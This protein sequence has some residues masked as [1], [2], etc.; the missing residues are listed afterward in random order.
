[1]FTVRQ[2]GHG[3]WGIGE[4]ERDNFLSFIGLVV[5][6]SALFLEPVDRFSTDATEEAAEA[7]SD[8][9]FEHYRKTIQSSFGMDIK[10]FKGKLV[11]GRADGKPL[12]KY[13]LN[14]LLPGIK[15]ELE[16]T[17]DKF[18]AL[19]IATDHLEEFPD[20]YTRLLDMEEKAE[21]EQKERAKKVNR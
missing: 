15:V 9:K 13:D 17:T 1:L 11:G 8:P 20:Y 18:L 3:F 16:H 4:W 21:R 12:T 14:E 19:E 10:N 2:R 5:V 7:K 6:N